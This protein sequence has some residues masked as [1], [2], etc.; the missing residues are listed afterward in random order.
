MNTIE[1]R[2]AI[3]TALGVPMKTKESNKRYIA[4]V[5]KALAGIEEPILKVRALNTEVVDYLVAQGV[6]AEVAVAGY[7]AP[8]VEA[9]VP[10]ENQEADGTEN[11]LVTD[12][13][14]AKAEAAPETPAKAATV[15]VKKAKRDVTASIKRFVY[16]NQDMSAADVLAGLAKA[17]TY[18][19]MS[20]VQTIR[21]DFLNSIRVLKELGVIKE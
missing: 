9:A 7:N 13:D 14:V 1:I 19:S 2:S 11:D 4:R 8:A 17:G 18:T 15:A 10:A 16:A 3:E 5:A 20:T 12:A 21:A 6:V